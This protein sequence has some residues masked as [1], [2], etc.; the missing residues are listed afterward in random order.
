MPRFSDVI[1]AHRR[2]LNLSSEEERVITKIKSN[3]KLPSTYAS[4]YSQKIRPVTSS[5]PLPVASTQSRLAIKPPSGRRP[6]SIAQPFSIASS[7]ANV[8][9]QRS[10][11][12]RTYV[13]SLLISNSTCMCTACVYSRL[14]LLEQEPTST[15]IYQLKTRYKS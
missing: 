15:T 6:S 10:R 11:L 7:A 3:N 14:L 4:P 1:S 13:S 2:E 5:Y 9:P 8:Q 12:K